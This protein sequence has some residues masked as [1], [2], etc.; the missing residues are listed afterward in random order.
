MPDGATPSGWPELGRDARK[1]TGSTHE[2]L[3]FSALQ[4]PDWTPPWWFRCYRRATP[5]EDAG[6]VDLIITIDLGD[7][8]VQIKSSRYGREQHRARHGTQQAIITVDECMSSSMIRRD[9]VRII[10]FR[11]VN[12]LQQRKRSSRR[13]AR[14]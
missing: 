14:T 11:R 9:L 2:F 5:D 13:R 1:E 12:I 3:V 10:G 8:E 7:I 6:G 4:A